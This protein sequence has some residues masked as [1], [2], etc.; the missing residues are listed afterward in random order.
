M[1]SITP[2][3]NGHKPMAISFPYQTSLTFGLPVVQFDSLPEREKK[4]CPDWKS[5]DNLSMLSTIERHLHDD[6]TLFTIRSEGDVRFLEMI[7]KVGNEELKWCFYCQREDRR[8]AALHLKKTLL[9]P[10]VEMNGE[11]RRRVADLENVIDLCV[12]Q[13]AQGRRVLEFNAATYHHGKNLEFSDRVRNGRPALFTVPLK[14]EDLLF[15]NMFAASVGETPTVPDS[16]AGSIDGSP[17]KSF[18]AAHSPDTKKPESL[19]S[20]LL[21][22]SGSR[23]RSLQFEDTQKVV[24]MSEQERRELEEEHR[25]KKAQPKP[26]KKKLC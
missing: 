11:W 16:S 23:Q 5:T 2:N 26:K 19:N 12:R 8:A 6:L 15:H 20:S 10:L 4:N 24:P 9:Q 1:K 3:G 7:G 13:R 25:R 21:N 14:D 17:H 22:S 18:H